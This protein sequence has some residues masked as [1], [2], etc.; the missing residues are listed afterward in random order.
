MPKGR[1]KAQETLISRLNKLNEIGIALSAN[2]GS[3]RL[4]ELILK[5]A[6][7]LTNADGGTL[8]T[9]TPHD[10]LKFE[11]VRTSSLNIAW[12]GPGH[13]P[14]PFNDI[15]LHNGEKPNKQMVVAY[16]ALTGQTINIPDAYE[17]TEFDLQGTYDFDKQMGYRSTSFLTVP[18]KDHEREVIGVLQ[19]INAKDSKTG[20]VR[21]F[22]EADQHL[23]ESLASQ[24]AVAMSNQRLVKN[25][26][27]ML[28]GFIWAIAEAIDDKSPYTGGHCRRVPIIANAL[29]EA[30]NHTH[31]GP[32][33]ARHFSAEEL[34]EL[35][36][37]SLLHDC[38]KITTPVHIVDKATRLE[39]I[40]DRI[41]AVERRFDLLHHQAEKELLERKLAALEAGKPIDPA[42]DKALA[43][44]K[45]QYEADKAFLRECNQGPTVMTA[46]RQEE[47]KRIAKY[48]VQRQ[49]GNENFL[50]D[51]EV[52][53][54][55]IPK[56][57]LTTEERDIIQQ[58]VVSSIKMLSNLPYPKH[59]RNVPEIAG[60]HHERMDGKGYPYG[61]TGE[62]MSVQ[63]R[64]LAVADV[65]EAL[66]APDRPYKNPMPMSQVLKIMEE[67]KDTG[68]IDPDIYDVFM[69]KK[70]YLN[71]G[72]DYLKPEQLD[73]E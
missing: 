30:I 49:G 2:F 18:L 12:G 29:A 1:P 38:G 24:A 9:V 58:H 31:D 43:T 50:T 45:A 7:E 42:W 65:F 64:L 22:E 48:Q 41:D 16:S 54:L 8:Y 63:A 37:A 73:V 66:T 60:N 6:K 57:T 4:M 56:G 25:L 47:V 21:P 67:A 34:Y 19:L 72:L 40:V 59:L 27:G 17:T 11:I 3:E 69:K 52:K 14:V 13:N 68:H 23:V 53:N 70:V 35:N 5:G 28:E 62:Q 51:E 71:Y 33:A 20:E 36:I 10:S 15:P 32:L 61:I 44:K 55:C 26:N 39:T 46:D